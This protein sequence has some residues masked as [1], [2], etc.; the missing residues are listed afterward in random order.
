VS[1]VSF[2]EMERWLL[3]LPCVGDQ[4]GD[5]IDGKVG[6]AAL[7][8]VFNLRDFLEP[9][10][11]VAGRTVN[12]QQFTPVIDNRVEPEATIPSQ[13]ALAPRGRRGKNL[14]ATDTPVVADRQ[15]GRIDECRPG[16]LAEAPTQI[17]SPCPQ[18]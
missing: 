5:R 1:Q 10:N 13:A 2:K 14:V 15:R 8:S 3:Q 7:T 4:P 16:P 17:E 12:R 6:R 18:G 11:D 9:V